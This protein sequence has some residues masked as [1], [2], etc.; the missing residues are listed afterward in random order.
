MDDLN[1]ELV[2]LGDRLDEM[3]RKLDDLLARM[4]MMIGAALLD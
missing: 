1:R 4:D 3:D 2:A